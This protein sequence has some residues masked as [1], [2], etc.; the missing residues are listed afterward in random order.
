MEL[1]TKGTARPAGLEFSCHMPAN[2]LGDFTTA[3]S[4]YKSKSLKYRKGCRDTMQKFVLSF[5]RPHRRKVSHYVS[6]YSVIYAFDKSHDFTAAQY[7]QTGCLQ[8][9]L[10]YAIFFIPLAL[11]SPEARDVANLECT[12]NCGAFRRDLWWSMVSYYHQ[13]IGE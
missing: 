6:F 9:A 11:R 3:I 13:N 7:R 8:L 12:S 1:T 5:R 10:I 4:T 2:D